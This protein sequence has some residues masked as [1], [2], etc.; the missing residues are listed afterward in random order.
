MEPNFSEN[1]PQPQPTVPE[2]PSTIPPQVTT[3]AQTQTEQPTLPQLIC[4][5]C[6]VINPPEFF[7]CPN[8]GKELR[9]KP[10]STS[11]PKQIG[12]YLLAFFLPPF[13]LSPGIKYLRR[14]TSKEKT[15][16]GIAII[17]TFLSIGFSIWLAVS[18]VTQMQSLITNQLQNSLQNSLQQQL[19]S[20]MEETIKKQINSQNL[21]F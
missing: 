11:V 12:I 4:S 17:L 2:V 3:S 20:G 8:C 21:G 18:V 14:N 15:V 5:Y 6:H 13:G 7:F 1:N 16:G 9:G 10:L 19:N